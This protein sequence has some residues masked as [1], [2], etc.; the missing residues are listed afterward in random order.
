MESSMARLTTAA[1]RKLP[2]KDFAVPS[3]APGPGSYPM[4][5]AK[6][7]ALAKGMAARFGSPAVKEAAAKKAADAQTTPAKK[8]VP[9]GRGSSS[10]SS[11]NK[12]R[13]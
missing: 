11:Q 13:K 1:R 7:R 8:T 3:K 12:V 5:D 4:P 10:W 6:H 2:L 9:K